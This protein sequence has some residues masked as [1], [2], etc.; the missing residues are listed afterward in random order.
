MDTT[1]FPTIS[2]FMIFSWLSTEFRYPEIIECPHSWL[3]R[4]KQWLL[5]FNPFEAHQLIKYYTIFFVFKRNDRQWA[6][7]AT[8]QC[9]MVAV[10]IR[11]IKKAFTWIPKRLHYLFIAKCPKKW[12]LEKWIP[13]FRVLI[14][15][16]SLIFTILQ[17]TSFSFTP[18]IVKCKDP[19]I[20]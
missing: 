7:D 4:G 20:R 17:F 11:D 3:K 1:A 18:K 2:F 16:L 5:E 9:A 15:K 14:H 19:R 13:H 12:T 10:W 6:L 8:K